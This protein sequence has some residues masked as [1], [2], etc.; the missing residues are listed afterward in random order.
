M[1]RGRLPYEPDVVL[2]LFLMFCAGTIW[3]KFWDDYRNL[4]TANEGIVSVSLTVAAIVQTN[5]TPTLVS[6]SEQKNAFS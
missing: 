4:V 1:L 3:E 5:T 6:R 2:L